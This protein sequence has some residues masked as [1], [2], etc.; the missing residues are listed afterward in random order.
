MSMDPSTLGLAFFEL[1][2]IANVI[3]WLPVAIYIRRDAKRCKQPLRH[4]FWT[5]FVYG[6]ALVAPLGIGIFGYF[7][8]FF[9]LYAYIRRRPRT[10]AV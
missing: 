1:L 8:P 5:V 6:P 7:S 10:R 3:I 2:Y 9:A 4:N